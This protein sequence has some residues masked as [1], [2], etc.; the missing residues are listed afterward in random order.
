MEIHKIKQCSNLQDW[1]E[2]RKPPKRCG[3]ITGERLRAPRWIYKQK[4]LLLMS[5]FVHHIF[6]IILKIENS[7]FV[8][9]SAV[10]CH[11]LLNREN[12]HTHEIDIESAQQQKKTKITQ[13]RV[14]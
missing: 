9:R 1:K 4:V 14:K 12:V 2:S 5:G 7:L 10:Y 6:N 11:K 3:I 8:F 13:Y